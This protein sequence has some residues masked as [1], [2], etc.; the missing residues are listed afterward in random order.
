MF[1]TGT[2]WAGM[3]ATQR[4]GLTLNNFSAQPEQFLTQNTP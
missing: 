1:L 3:P 4:Q 2:L